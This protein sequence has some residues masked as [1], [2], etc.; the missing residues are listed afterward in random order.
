MRASL[1][2]VFYNAVR[3]VV[4]RPGGN[5][6]DEEEDLQL[7]PNAGVVARPAFVARAGDRRLPTGAASLA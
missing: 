7:A 5:E 1:S 4:P 2:N 3:V 6:R